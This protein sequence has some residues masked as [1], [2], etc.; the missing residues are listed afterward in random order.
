MDIVAIAIGCGIIAVVYGIITSRQVLA[1]SPGNARM[2][3][4]AKAIQEGAGAYL[5]K[6]YTAI[7][8]VGVIVAALVAGFLGVIPAVAFVLGAVLSGVTGFIG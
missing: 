2:Q 4:I 6:Q 1:A 3:E 7:A 8:I 5:T